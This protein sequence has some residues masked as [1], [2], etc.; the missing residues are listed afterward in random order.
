M[1]LCADDET[2]QSYGKIVIKVVGKK[3]SVDASQG[4][5]ERHEVFQSEQIR[6]KSCIFDGGKESSWRQS[7]GSGIYKVL[8]ILED[9]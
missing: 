1:E 7:R 6:L 3:E 8:D 2:C 4:M 5:Q 9:G